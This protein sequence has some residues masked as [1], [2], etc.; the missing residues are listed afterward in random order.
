[1][2]LECFCNFHLEKSV[3]GVII[4]KNLPGNEKMLETCYLY[5]KDI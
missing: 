3:Y 5:A 2:S 1:M 4:G